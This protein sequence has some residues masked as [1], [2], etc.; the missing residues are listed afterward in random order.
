MTETLERKLEEMSIPDLQAYAAELRHDFSELSE[1]ERSDDYST[2]VKAIVENVN[3]LDTHLTLARA[4]EYREAA[5]PTAATD[6]VGSSG[7][8]SI[9]DRIMDHDA[10]KA[11]IDGG[12][13]GGSDTVIDYLVDGSID[14]GLRAIINEFGSGGPGNNA[15][16]GVNSLL[17][18]GQPIPPTPRQGRLFMRDLIPVQPT[19][20]TQVPY[21]RELNPVSLEGGASAVSEGSVKPDVGLSLVPET[22]YVTVV[23]GNVSPTKQLW[24]DAPLVVAYINQRLPYLVKLR[25]DAEILAGSGTYPDIQGLKNVTGV[26][27]QGATSGETAITIGNAIAKVELVDGSATAVVMNPTDAWSMFIKRAAGGSGTFDAGTPFSAGGFATVWGLPVMRSRIYAQGN[28]LVG[29]Y[30]RGAMILDREQVNVQ[31]Y[32]QHSDYAARN[33]ILVQA[34]ERVGLMTFR[35]DYFV[36]TTIS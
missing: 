26:Q 2:R 22:A 24:Q 8:R 30:Q 12:L 19:T 23:A 34:E 9:G 20:L 33:A 16:N 13:R 27:S 15:A 36:S 28:A 11:W 6:D 32:P 17:P 7:T 35:P 4:Q 3:A 21:V 18:V 10:M 1:G 31:V 29:D 25:E 14:A 5:L